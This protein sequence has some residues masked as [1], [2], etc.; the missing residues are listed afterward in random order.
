M[1]EVLDLDEL[2]ARLA[3]AKGE[4]EE[5]VDPF[6]RYQYITPLTQAM[7]GYI[8][9]VRTE[10]NFK[11]GL[12]EIDVVTRGFG[13]GH[14]VIVFGASHSGKTQ[15]VMNGVHNNKHK[16]VLW[17]C[18]DEPAEL[19]FSKLAALELGLDAETIEQRVKANDVEMIGGLLAV[20]TSAY[21]NLIVVDRALNEKELWIAIQEAE[22]SWGAPCDLTV[23]DY[24]EQFPVGDTDFGGVSKKILTFKHLSTQLDHPLLVIH[25]TSRSAGALGQP[26]GRRAMRHGGENEATFA[27]EVFRKRE[28]PELT[29]FERDRADRQVSVNICKNKRPPARLKMLDLYMDPTTGK[30]RSWRDE[31][32]RISPLDEFKRKQQAQVPPIINQAFPGS[33]FTQYDGEDF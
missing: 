20:A 6:D 22:D 28:N 26:L 19:V 3:A 9:A 8:E 5:A 30:I 31:D 32:G 1:A 33:D 10:G 18:P 14:L 17:V 11:L 25:Q 2:R 12:P 27:I 23:Y 29:Q 16:H 4:T 24:L 13:A 21:P 7:D 15:L